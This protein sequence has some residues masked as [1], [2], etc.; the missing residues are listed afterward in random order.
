M[1]ISATPIPGNETSVGRIIN[2]LFQLGADV[3]YSALTTV[4]VSGHASREALTLMLNLTR[5]KYVMPLPVRQ[6]HL[7][8]YKGRGDD[9]GRRPVGAGLRSHPSR[10]A[11]AAVRAT[12]I[13]RHRSRI[14]AEVAACAGNLDFVGRCR[15]G[16][17]R[18]LEHSGPVALGLGDRVGE[19][20]QPLRHRPVRGHAHLGHEP[21]QRA[22]RDEDVALRVR[23][24]DAVER[25]VDQRG[26]QQRNT[27]VRLLA[28]P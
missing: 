28:R 24:A 21:P 25:R 13:L 9:R 15:A 8:F 10:R 16:L 4:P 7:T 22:V 20:E 3:I 1:I 14:A 27:A 5:T 18:E 2:N 17:V 12:R 6:R 11:A 19:G 26:L 23:Q